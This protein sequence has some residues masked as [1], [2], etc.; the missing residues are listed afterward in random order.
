M[1]TVVK[2][3]DFTPQQATQLIKLLT[4]VPIDPHE[5]EQKKW[6]KQ[7][8]KFGAQKPPVTMYTLLEDKQHVSIPFRFACTLFG[9]MMNQDLPHG[10]VITNNQPP[11]RA[12]LRDYQVEPAMEAH[13][14]L[15]TYGTTTIGLPPGFGKTMI[16]MWLWYLA[17]VVGLFIMHRDTIARAWMKTVIKC[18]PDLAP[19]VWFVGE[20]APP[21]PGTIPPIIICMDGRMS[22]IPSYIKKAVGFLC[23]DEV[24]LFCTPGRV[25]CFLDPE[26]N[27]RYVVVESATVERDDGMHSMVHAVVGMHGVFRVSS[28]PYHVIQIETGILVEEKRTSWGTSFDEMCKQLAASQARNLMMVDIVISNPHRKFIILTR[29]ADHVELIEAF[30]QHYGIKVGTL[31]KSKSTYS[32]SPVLIGTMPKMGTGFD[33]ANA[34]DD[35][36]GDESNVLIMAHTVKKWQLFEQLRGRIMRSRAPV[37]LWLADKNKMG[38]RHLKGLEPWIEN[39]NGKLI[40]IQYVQGTIV[41]PVL[42]PKPV[43]PEAPALSGTG[44]V[45]VVAPIGGVAGEVVVDATAPLLLPIPASTGPVQVGLVVRKEA[46]PMDKLPLP[47]EAIRPADRLPMPFDIDSIPPLPQDLPVPKASRLHIMS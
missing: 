21:A 37:V 6:G 24:H 39:T 11:F 4:L 36:Q 10:R 25:H 7:K 22:K 33:E 3:T 35:F 42:P 17:G 2:L 13:K 44:G 40:Q 47:E 30:M 41:L 14:Q 16:G 28:Q 8:R 1:A 46:A 20:S 38:R 19:Y 12:T 27:P 26:I 34:C 5:E 45:C 43:T 32:D 29:L 9:R 18:V 31:Y 23:I 15:F